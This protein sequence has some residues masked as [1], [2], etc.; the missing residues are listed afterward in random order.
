MFHRKFILWEKGFLNGSYTAILKNCIVDW[1]IPDNILMIGEAREMHCFVG[2][3]NKKKNLFLISIN[4]SSITFSS[5]SLESDLIF[6]ETAKLG[7]KFGNVISD[8]YNFE[9]V[10]SGPKYH[11]FY[12]I[13]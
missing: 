7:N 3:P 13:V 9:P 4:W 10:T 8:V 6:K 5:M 2:K 11:D 1:Y 12:K